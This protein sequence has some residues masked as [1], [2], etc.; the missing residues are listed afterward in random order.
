MFE[1]ENTSIKIE[2]ATFFE[3]HLLANISC[4]HL[5]SSS[6]RNDCCCP[7]LLGG[8]IAALPAVVTP[9]GQ[10]GNYIRKLKIKYEIDR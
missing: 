8:R 2:S 7:R 9:S 4:G 10:S 6:P 5:S 1:K 3:P